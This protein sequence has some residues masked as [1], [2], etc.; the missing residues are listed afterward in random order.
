VSPPA[1]SPAAA[2]SPTLI[3]TV[4]APSQPSE[5]G[6]YD[7]LVGRWLRPDGGYILEVRSVSPEGAVDASYLNPRPIHVARAEASRMGD[8]MTLF[9]ELRDANYPGS[10][11]R[12]LYDRK[13]DMLT[14]SYFQALQQ[15][16]F[17]VEFVRR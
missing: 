8:G 9:V 16:T 6:G 2:A 4:P 1:P 7:R 14:G 10:T 17:E 13:R 12:L 15:Q 11:Y 5:T 3:P